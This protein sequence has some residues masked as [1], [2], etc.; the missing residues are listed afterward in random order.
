[1]RRHRLNLVV[2]ILKVGYVIHEAPL[3]IFLI[4]KFMA[5]TFTMQTSKHLI[6]YYPHYMVV[7]IL[8][9]QINNRC[10]L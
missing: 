7:L 6:L 3:K 5:T 1:M 9:T 8:Y 2:E 4:Y 10:L